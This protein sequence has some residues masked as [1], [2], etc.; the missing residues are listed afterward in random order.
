MPEVP[1]NRKDAAVEVGRMSDLLRIYEHEYHVLG[2][3][4]V[5]DLTYDKLFDSLVELEREYPELKAPDSPTARVGSDLS[6][7]F[8]EFEHTIPVLSL[9]KAYTEEEIT[10]WIDRVV[11]PEDL[12]LSVVVE[13]KIDGISIVL[14]Y[15]DGVL[16][17]AVTRGNGIVGNEVTANIK[18]IST[19]PLRLR[20]PINATVRGEVYLPMEDFESYNQTLDE[21][22]ANPRNLAAG[23]MRR[24][25]SE[26]AAAIPLSMFAYEAFIEGVST[27]IEALERIEELGFRRNRRVG[28]FSATGEVAGRLES[29]VCGEFRDLVPYIA[30]ET[31]E[32]RSLGYEIDGLVLKV[33]ELRVREELGYTGHHPRWA[34]AF[35]FE[36]PEGATTISGIDIQVG[37]TGRITPVARVSPVSISG[38][39]ISN[40][41]L[42][43]Q[44]YV[45]MLELAIGDSVVVSRRGDVIPAVERVV[46]K[47]EIGNRTWEMPIQCPSCDEPLSIQGAHH[48]CTNRLCP[49]QVRGRLYFF[50]GRDQMDIDNV[51]PETI[52]VLVREGLV[53]DLPDL[54]RFDPE[55]LGELPGFGEKKIELIRL[56]IEKSLTKPFRT[57]LP[58]LGIPELGP[59]VTELLLDAGILGIDELFS[60]AESSEMDRLIE[61]P[62]IKNKTT[63]RIISELVDDANRDR[64]EAL[65]SVGLRFHEE[66]EKEAPSNLI[67]ADQ[68]WCVTGS[69]DRFKPRSAAV[70]EVKNRGGGVTTQVSGKTTHLLA[71]VNPGSKL[72]K[73]K[74]L[75]IEIVDERMFLQLLEWE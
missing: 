35:K 3:P 32:R 68:I 2:K 41:T 40:V 16:Q 24:L 66:V 17:R 53:S 20:E 73:A 61:I 38:T 5:S 9:D 7:D 6:S 48:F 10:K 72:E 64:I 8:P 27:H 65:R 11:G 22:Y 28:F 57:V 31:A 46:E 29:V 54:Y 56:G 36:S 18:T 33:N 13:E 14:Y 4:S 55:T 30:K 43:N 59:K 49:A 12:G 62:G 63:E 51:G 50:V 19:V 1:L 23:T 60:I 42:H 44:E 52:D 70:V 21:P 67:F 75:G 71:G 26:E 69:F 34:I 25:K 15:E 58:S 39:T 74:E 37:R 47:N 45:N